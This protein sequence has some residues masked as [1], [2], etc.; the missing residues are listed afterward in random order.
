MG[1]RPAHRAPST[2]PPAPCIGHCGLDPLPTLLAPLMLW[3][4]GVLLCVRVV[5][6]AASGLPGRRDGVRP[7][8]PGNPA[9]QRP[10][11]ILGPRY[12]GSSDSVSWSRSGWPR[13]VQRDLRRGEGGR[14]PVLPRCRTSAS[15]RASGVPIARASYAS[16]FAV[17][18]VAAVTPVVFDLENAVLIGPYEPR[19][20]NLR[21]DRP[22]RLSHVAPLPDAFF[23]DA[24]A[25][26]RARGPQIGS[27][28]GAD[29]RRRR[30]TTSSVERGRP[31]RGDPCARDRTGDAGALPCRG[32]FRALPGVRP[33][34]NLVVDLGRLR[35]G[36]GD[37]GR[38][39]LPRSCRGPESRPAWR[40]RRQRSEPA[41][42]RATRSISI[43]PRRRSTRI[44]RA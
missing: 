17:A 22:R 19:R 16:R 12:A 37:P 25:R 43:P 14:R 28:R 29:R 27:R 32:R 36:D 31:R 20:A 11:P 4:G 5:L 13:V 23:A 40:R 42:A 41:L 30:R 21:G 1:R 38:R 18:G 10:A 3:V 26:R 8:R 35:G 34:A 44:S 9:P 39:L 2:H 7:R 24:T 6:A 33:G 15:P